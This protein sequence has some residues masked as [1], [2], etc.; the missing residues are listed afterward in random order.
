MKKITSLVLSIS[1]WI[2]GAAH[3]LAQSAS[4]E[5]L[6]ESAREALYAEKRVDASAM[7]FANLLPFAPGSFGA[8]DWVSG[9]F[10]SAFDA[11]ALALLAYGAVGA[12]S[13]GGWSLI[14]GLGWGSMVYG[15]GRLIGLTTPWFYAPD[16]NA[17]LRDELGLSPMNAAHRE[18]PQPLLS[19]AFA[20]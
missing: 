15:A 16:H 17:R 2:G 6:P 7:A 20:F 13:S 19:Y 10:V 9:S 12:G 4:Y 18:I 1:L 11:A 5:L 8:G 3:A 14:F